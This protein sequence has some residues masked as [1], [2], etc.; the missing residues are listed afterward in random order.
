MYVH[1][2]CGENFILDHVK[3]STYFT[4][5]SLILS[6]EHC[7]ILKIKYIIF[8]KFYLKTMEIKTISVCLH[9]CICSMKLIYGQIDC[10]YTNLNQENEVGKIHKR[11]SKRLHTKTVQLHFFISLNRIM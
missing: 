2:K 7:N 9:C 1:E 11:N 6:N 5:T 8:Y 10:I 3:N 4:R